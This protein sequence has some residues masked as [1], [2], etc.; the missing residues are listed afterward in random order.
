MLEGEQTNHLEERKASGVS[1]RRNGRAIERARSLSSG[2]LEIESG[3]DREGTFS[4]KI[5]LKR[6][7]ILTS[8]LEEKVTAMYA[9][10]MSTRDNSGG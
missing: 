3:R 6:Q 4:P 10:G 2:H 7:L 1:N 5:L 9:K 8:D